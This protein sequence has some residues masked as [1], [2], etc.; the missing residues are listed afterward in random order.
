MH[1]LSRAGH[2][3]HHAENFRRTETLSAK[4]VLRDATSTNTHVAADQQTRMSILSRDRAALDQ[5]GLWPS[6]ARD[7]MASVSWGS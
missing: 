6:A 3:V 5:N 1:A 7:S 4:K 2:I